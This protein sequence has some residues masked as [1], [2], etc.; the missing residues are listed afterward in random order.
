MPRHRVI[1]N[2]G[3]SFLT[4][5]S[6]GY[7]RIFDPTNGYTAIHATIASLLPFEHV[8][9]RFFFETDILFY[10]G[11]L[12]AVVVDIPLM[13]HYPSE[14]SHLSA[15]SV[16]LPFACLHLRRFLRRILVNYFIRDFSLGSICLAVGFALSVS[17]AA[18]AL[19]NWLV[20]LARGVATPVGTIMLAV[21]CM[22]LGIQLILFFF[23]T[24]LA[25]VPT[26]PLHGLLRQ[27]PARPLRQF[28]R[29]PGDAEASSHQDVTAQF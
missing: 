26:Q 16:L 8:S 14:G 28:D 15:R 21:L 9:N 6:T 13:A 22:L 20:N 1:G 17:G 2:A 12:R 4:K 3:L 18:I 5:L 11:S 29:R 7:W 25:A 23:A 24:D 27:R 19:A 10:L